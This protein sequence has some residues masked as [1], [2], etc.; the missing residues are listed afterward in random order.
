VPASL[1]RDRRGVHEDD[2]FCFAMGG[3][4]FL[5]KLLYGVK[6]AIVENTPDGNA[7]RD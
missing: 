5:D 4:Y 6:P 3:N 2:P 7:G 1:A